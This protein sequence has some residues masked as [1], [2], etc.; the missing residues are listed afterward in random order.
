MKQER[1]AKLKTD[2]G[3][4]MDQSASVLGR[5]RGRDAALGVVE[6]EPK[7]GGDVVVVGDVTRSLRVQ[8]AAYGRNETGS[9]SG[10]KAE[11]TFKRSS[12]ER[13]ASASA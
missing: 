7:R 10:A 8:A 13:S 11:R 4:T 5:K 1:E 6:M 3:L 2:S 9:K 12:G